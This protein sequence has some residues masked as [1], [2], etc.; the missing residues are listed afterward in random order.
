[1][2]NFNMQRGFSVIE[3]VILIAVAGIIGTLGWKFYDTA[4]NKQTVNN[5]SQR[6]DLDMQPAD[7]DGIVALA[8]IQQSAIAG[9][10]DTTVDHVELELGKDGALVYKAQLS[11][12]TVSIYDA[13]TG[14]LVRT[15]TDQEKTNEILP[16]SFDGGIGFAKALEIAKSE[17]PESKVFKIELELEGGIVVY[18]V[19]F[20]DKARVDVNAED[21]SIVRTKASKADKNA[22]KEESKAAKEAA[23]AAENEE[24][25]AAQSEAKSDN[26]KS[27]SDDNDSQSDSA[28]TDS[29]DDDDD[30]SDNDDD[31]ADDDSDSRIRD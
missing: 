13:R 20:G 19:R 28:D 5:V 16:A 25:K 26:K 6:E 31:D 30:L 24:K 10:T 23:K 12:G 27:N 7:L 8:T 29:S 11:D 3:V 2:S 22:A 4:S 17:K 9:K 15:S 18:S 1:M 14:D 21:G